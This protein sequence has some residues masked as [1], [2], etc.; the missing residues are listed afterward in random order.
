MTLEVM[1]SKFWAIATQDIECYVIDNNGF[2]L[3]SKN[4]NNAGRF[5]G[6]IDGSVMT[7]LIRMGMFKRVS[8]FD[9]QAMCKMNSHFVSS[10]RP[11]LSPFYGLASVL[12]WFLS[13]FLLMFVVQQIPESNLL[14]LVVQADCDCSRQYPRITMEPKEVKYIL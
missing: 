1:E 11:L 8:L 4:Y 5:F 7:T 3:I 2:V 13:N 12:K 9:Y 10:A 14:M 6:E